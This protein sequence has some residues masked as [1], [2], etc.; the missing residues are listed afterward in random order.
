MA[1][2]GSVVL[3]EKQRERKSRPEN[4]NVVYKFICH[5]EECLLRPNVNYICVTTSLS[6][7]LTMHLAN[8][9]IKRHM[10][11]IHKSSLNRRQLTENTEIIK[12]NNDVNRLQIAEAGHHEHI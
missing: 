9:A 5:H 6:R 8:G 11:K 4:T 10:E 7:R 12:R 1:Q 3:G 2:S